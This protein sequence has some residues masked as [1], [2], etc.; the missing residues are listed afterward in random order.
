MDILRENTDKNKSQ[1]LKYN[2]KEDMFISEK[3]G[4][5]RYQHKEHLTNQ[6]KVIK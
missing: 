6:G 2:S 3:D 4:S 5:L 1:I